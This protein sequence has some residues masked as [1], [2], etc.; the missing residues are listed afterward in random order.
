MSVRP[1]PLP[2]DA[3]LKRYAE[4]STAYTDCFADDVS[5]GTDLAAFVGAFYTTWLFRIE[6]FILA[7]AGHP[8]TDEEVGALVAG[9]GERFAAWTVEARASEQ[10]LMCDVAQRTRS[11]FMVKDGRAYFGSAVVHGDGARSTAFRWLLPFHRL[12]ARALL[13]LAVRRLRAA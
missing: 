13:A 10:L 6:R 3:L 9:E 5:A 11:W 1:A 4:S 8:S 2:E 7:R 12:Y